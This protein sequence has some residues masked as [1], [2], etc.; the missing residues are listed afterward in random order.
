M[1]IHDCSRVDP[2]LFHEFHQSWS[3]RLKD[4]LNGGKLPTG[5][6]A[7]VEQHTGAPEPDIIA[8]NAN[9]DGGPG[10]AVGVLTRPRTATRSAIRQESLR[11]AERANRITVQHPLGR[12]VAVIEVVSSGNKHSKRAVKDFVSKVDELLRAGIHVAVI[13][14]FPHTD[15]D[16]QGLH[17]LIVECYGHDPYVPPAD[18]PLTLSSYVVIPYEETTAYVEPSAVGDALFPMP[19]FLTADYYV[20][21]PLEETYAATWAACP[22][23]IRAL[24]A[25]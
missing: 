22:E 5:Y 17:G 10:G 7:L 24:V 11:Y 13:D 2:R 15:R 16:P 9:F 6:F 19:L 25:G 18:K 1:P 12:T 20:D 3:V 8:L 21:L 4:A 14:L 23:P